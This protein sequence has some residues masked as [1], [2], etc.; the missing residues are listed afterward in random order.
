[1]KKS[2]MFLLSSLIFL[3]IDAQYKMVNG[4]YVLDEPVNT[5]LPSAFIS[6]E[7]LSDFIFKRLIPEINT[8]NPAYQEIRLDISFYRISGSAPVYVNFNLT[9]NRHVRDLSFI[10]EAEKGKAYVDKGDILLLIHDRDSIAMKEGIISRAIGDSIDMN[11]EYWTITNVT[12]DSDY[13][14]YFFA[15][16]IEGDSLFYETS[17]KNDAEYIDPCLKR[18]DIDDILPPKSKAALEREQRKDKAKKSTVP[19]IEPKV[20]RK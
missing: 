4:S 5:R 16:A 18:T 19:A 3:Q 11:K 7:Q 6:H 20:L 14:G 17:K 10:E 1:M 2:L 9:R 13:S 15:F 12:D 8:E